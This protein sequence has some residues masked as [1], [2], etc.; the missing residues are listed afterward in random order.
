L[1]RQ[2]KTRK[3]SNQSTGLD[4]QDP[5]ILVDVVD[6]M[7]HHAVVVALLV[8]TIMNW[9][10]INMTITITVVS[11]TTVVNV[12]TAATVEAATVEAVT[13]EAVTVEAVTVEAVTV[14][15]MTDICDRDG[16]AAC[17]DICRL[18]RTGF[19]NE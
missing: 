16:L 2:Q 13:V 5:F 1:K 8:I 11:A 10:Q 14:T 15:L 6:Q 4:H 7:I 9:L 17:L 19:V 3:P 12:I 18:C